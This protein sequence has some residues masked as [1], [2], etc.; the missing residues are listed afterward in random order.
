MLTNLNVT[1]S[2]KRQ[3]LNEKETRPTNIYIHVYSGPTDCVAGK[4]IGPAQWLG[5]FGASH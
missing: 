4:F 5:F 2:V 1:R 3:Q